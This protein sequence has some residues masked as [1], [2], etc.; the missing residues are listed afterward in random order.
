MKTIKYALLMIIVIMLTVNIASAQEVEQVKANWHLAERFS[1]DNLKKMTYD[2]RVSPTWLKDSDKF[3]YKFKTSEGTNYYIVDPVKRS[4]DFLF[5]N[6]HMAS[7]LTILTKKPH[8]SK[9][10]KIQKLEFIDDFNAMYVDVDSMRYKYDLRDNT[11]TEADSIPKKPE[12]WKTFSPDSTY[13]VFARDH[14][15][16]VMKTGDP[17]SVDIQLTTDGE[18]WY[19]YASSPGDTTVGKRVR[20][21]ASWFNDSKTLRSL[22]KDL[23]EVED[24]WVINSLSKPRPTLETYRYQMAGDEKIEIQ[25]LLIFDIETKSRVQIDTHKWDFQSTGGAYMTSGGIYHGNLSDKV[26]FARR[27]REYDKLELCVGD[28]KTGESRVLVSEEMKPYFNINEMQFAELNDGEEFIWYAE[29]TGWGQLY[30]YDKD[31]NMKNQITDGAFTVS[32]IAKIDTAK[33]VL[34]F[35]ANGKEKDIDP[36]FYMYYK[37]NLDGTGMQLVTPED[38]NHTFS[39]S[40]SRKYFVDTYSRVDLVPRAILKDNSGNKIL[41]LEEAD[42]S[43]LLEAGFQMP[44][45]FIIK[46]EDGITDHH[47]VMWKPFDFDPNKKYPIITYVYPGPF[48]E[49]IPKRFSPTNGNVTLSQVGFIVVCFGNRG[50]SPLRGSFYHTYGHGN[51]RNYGLADKKAVIKNLAARHSFIDVS[52]VGIYGHS[53]GGFMS[54]AALLVYPDFFKVAVSTAGNHDNNIYNIWWGE[55]NYG[56]KKK[57]VKSKEEGEEDKFTWE[58]NFPTN[59][60]IAKNLKGH[61]LIAHGA[62]DSNVHPANSIRVVDALIKA[63]KRFDFLLLPG[64]RHGFGSYN[65]YFGQRRMEYFAEHLLGDYKT[66]IEMFKK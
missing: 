64:K 23:R 48:S 40:E 54:T 49:A 31:G 50:G 59:W 17:D 25:E 52:K 15:L 36:Y 4:K 57:T 7:Q 37:I 51:A 2:L 46:A 38:A 3:W 26:Y 66:D 12:R 13:V 14:N 56:V 65:K 22:R 10:L 1:S 55:S 34:Y 60:E 5:D 16:Y 19:S 9:D 39:M 28:T 58:T 18:K 43:R 24:L 6:E 29:R 42:V 62:I 30:L 45:K 61:L 47:G 41:D 27:T 33:R 63:G 32:S 21:N 53:G 20:S 8:N 44:E 35:S 11:L